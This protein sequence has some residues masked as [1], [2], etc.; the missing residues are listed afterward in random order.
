MTHPVSDRLGS[1][2]AAALADAERRGLPDLQP[3]LESLARATRQIRAA[4]WNDEATSWR[5]PTARPAPD[6]Q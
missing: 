1:W 4:D 5:G 6:R 2:L 3:L